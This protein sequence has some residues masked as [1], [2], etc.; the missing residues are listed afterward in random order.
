MTQKLE[1]YKCEKCGNIVMVMH[2]GPGELVCCNQPMGLLQE[3]STDAAVEKH[4]P[5][6]E[7]TADGTLVVVGGVPHPMQDEH[8]IEW[9]E[10]Q[11]DGHSHIAF[12]E[13]GAAPSAIFNVKADNVKA[14]SYCNLHGFW[15]SA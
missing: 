4:V 14:R 9:I 12:L 8:Y 15:K 7:Q 10:L 11:H 1:V 2:A 6:V 5:V 3:N 13:P